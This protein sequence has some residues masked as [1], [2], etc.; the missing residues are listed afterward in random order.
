MHTFSVVLVTV[1]IVSAC[2]SQ[3][4]LGAG[5]PNSGGT[6]SGETVSAAAGQLTVSGIP[7]KYLDGVILVSGMNREGETF[8]Y[9]PKVLQRITGSAMAVK[10]YSKAAMVQEPFAGNGEYTVTVSLHAKDGH[11]ETRVF[12]RPFING[13][14]VLDWNDIPR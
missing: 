8:S 7:E 12:V 6:D 11:A 10:L 1:F 5:A 14:A 3:N 2:A 9:S 13:G 4:P